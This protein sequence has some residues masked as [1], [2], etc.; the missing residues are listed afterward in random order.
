MN[1]YLI[2][3]ARVA[4]ALLGI[5]IIG[6]FTISF[7]AGGSGVSRLLPG[8]EGARSVGGGLLGA[9]VGF[10]AGTMAAGLTCGI[11]AVWLDIPV[12]LRQ[13]R[14]AISRR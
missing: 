9:L 14:D 13:I 4:N 11:I 10:G 8:Y 6:F 12:M 3:A 1:S 5:G 7:A 2:W